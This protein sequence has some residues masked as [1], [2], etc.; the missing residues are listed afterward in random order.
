M[1]GVLP[2]VLNSHI[3]P[4]RFAVRYHSLLYRP[5]KFHRR[6]RCLL[7]HGERAQNTRRTGLEVG[8]QVR[9]LLFWPRTSH[10]TVLLSQAKSP[11]PER[12]GHCRAKGPALPAHLPEHGRGS[13]GTRVTLNTGAPTPHFPMPLAGHQEVSCSLTP[14]LGLPHAK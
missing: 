3:F 13:L 9:V 6:P 11:L 4:E 5:L 14:S 1:S 7:T 12:P 10:Q 2:N 8:K